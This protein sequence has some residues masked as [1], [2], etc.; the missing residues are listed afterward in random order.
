M[1]ICT[2]HLEARDRILISPYKIR[3]P[4]NDE[5]KKNQNTLYVFE[6]L[7]PPYFSGNTFIMIKPISLYTKFSVYSYYLLHSVV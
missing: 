6:L 1:D 4:C 3:Q 2:L 5:Q 7:E